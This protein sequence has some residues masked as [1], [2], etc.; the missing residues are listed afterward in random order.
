MTR[1]ENDR[2]ITKS[3][4]KSDCAT[5]L[6]ART[7]KMFMINPITPNIAAKLPINIRHVKR[8]Q[9]NLVK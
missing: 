9:M 1:S 3:V 2:D 8:R 6:R 7:T 5:C 4:G